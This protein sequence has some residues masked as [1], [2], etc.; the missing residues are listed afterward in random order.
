MKKV[1]IKIPQKIA[2]DLCYRSDRVC[3]VCKAPGDHIHHLD[4]NPSN[5]EIEN[6]VLLCF[7]HHDDI[8]AK[9]TLSRKLSKGVL[10]RYREQH[11]KQVERKRY[12]PPL[13]KNSKSRSLITE[14]IF[15]RL[16]LDALVCMEVEKIRSYLTC[17]NWQ[18][19]QKHIYELNS[20]PLEID[21][22]AKRAI[23]YALDDVSSNTR[24]KMPLLVAQ[25]VKHIA[26][27]VLPTR[28]LKLEKSKLISEEEKEIL[29]IG[30][31]IGF[32]M[33]YD[34]VKYLHNLKI[35]DEGV[36]ILWQVLCFVN[37]NQIKDIKKYTSEEFTQL[38]EIAEKIG[39]KY[40]EI[41]FR[42]YH[43]HG[44]SGK[45]QFPEYPKELALKL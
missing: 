27:S 15:F 40:S 9:R 24:H 36:Q 13:Y 20:F 18:T 1:K 22:R 23:L 29:N 12:L 28:S 21:W 19:I 43:K 32:N 11:Y 5:N 39:D 45:R 14:D 16:T 31:E 10:L 35:A 34:A 26:S 6:L 42:L 30:I 44:L 7:R 17:H 38:E 33:A 3:V 8:S 2:D 41:L 37:Q 25:A 4:G